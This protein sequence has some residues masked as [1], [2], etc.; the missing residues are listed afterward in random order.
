[1]PVKLLK[2]RLGK[3]ILSQT[4]GNMYEAVLEILPIEEPMSLLQMLRG[5]LNTA[6]MCGGAC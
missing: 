4:L 3:G 6:P 2:M 1:M 5:Q